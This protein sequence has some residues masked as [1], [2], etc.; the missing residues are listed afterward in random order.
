MILNAH[1]YV[2]ELQP[3][4]AVPPAAPLGVAAVPPAPLGVAAAPAGSAAVPPAPLGVAAAPAGSAAVHPAPLGVAAVPAGS[5]AVPPAPPCPSAVATNTNN[6]GV[7]HF[8][9]FD[10]GSGSIDNCPH[11]ELYNSNLSHF[12]MLHPSWQVTLWGKDDVKKLVMSSSPHL[13]S[14]WEHLESKENRNPFYLLDFSRYVVL[15]LQGGIYIDLDIK[16]LREL[17]PNKQYVLSSK[18]PGQKKR[19]ITNSF[20]C[21]T[22]NG[23]Y[24]KLIQFIISKYFICEI[25]KDWDRHLLHSVGALAFSSFCGI[26][27]IKPTLTDECDWIKDYGTTAWVG[28]NKTAKK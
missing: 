7:A 14:F 24:E 5:A 27:K 26:M 12:R 8:M 10:V 18:K 20:M 13:L 16:V 22:Q 3:P 21:L 23:I 28:L 6:G 9:F 11:S 25:N 1:T 4:V 19:K 17:E 15:A 2:L